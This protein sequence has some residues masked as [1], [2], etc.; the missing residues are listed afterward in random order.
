MKKEDF[1]F[2]KQMFVL[3]QDQPYVVQKIEIMEL[4]QIKKKSEFKYMH[5]LR[6]KIW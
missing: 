3:S 2:E 6:K 5:N 1:L 4:K